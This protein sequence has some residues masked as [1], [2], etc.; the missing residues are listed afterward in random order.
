MNTPTTYCLLL[1][2]L[3]AGCATPTPPFE[4]RETTKTV[5]KLKHDLEQADELLS[6]TETET[7]EP[8]RNE[9]GAAAEEFRAAVDRVNETLTALKQRFAAPFQALRPS[10][11]YG[12]KIA[13]RQ[14]PFLDAAPPNVQIESSDGTT[15][16][17]KSSGPETYHAS[18]NH[19]LTEGSCFAA[20]FKLPTPATRGG[21]PV[22]YFGIRD[23][24]GQEQVLVSFS[25][26]AKPDKTYEIFL[27]RKG[28]VFAAFHDGTI[29]SA[30]MKDTSGPIFP[31]F[32]LNDRSSV[33]L[34]EV[35][36]PPSSDDG[37]AATNTPES[38]G[39]PAERLPTP[40]M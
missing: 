39:Q 10:S 8:Y 14:K 36:I 18:I 7:G 5:F 37:E 3:L 16:I 21:T 2:L 19:Q 33:I 29:K 6:L 28:D 40:S 23:A 27:F 9:L 12:V 25:S 34:V 26:F 1:P 22:P 38:V 4:V 20:K 24:R 11:V 31:F 30:R 15:V 13:P 32:H 35:R 17:T